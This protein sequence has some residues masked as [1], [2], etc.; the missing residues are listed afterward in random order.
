MRIC[1]INCRAA[2]HYNDRIRK[3]SN[4]LKAVVFVWVHST[5]MQLCQSVCAERNIVHL[6]PPEDNDVFATLI[7]M[8]TFGQMMLCPV[9]TNEKPRSEERGFLSYP[10]N[11]EP[12]RTH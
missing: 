4:R 11:F 2:V 9:D 5:K 6:C 3:Q 10:N 8:L 7:M 12:F 1:T